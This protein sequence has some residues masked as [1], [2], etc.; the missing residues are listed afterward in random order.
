MALSAGAR[1]GPYEILSPLGAGGMG[2]VYRARDSRLGREVA[3]KVLPERFADDPE[4]M[5]RFEREARAVA[6]L[7]HPNIL[8]LHDAGQEAGVSYAVMELLEGQTLREEINEGRIPARKAADY[9]RQTADGL[10]AA[11]EKGV[12]HRDLKPENLFLTRDGRVKILDFGLARLTPFAQASDSLSPTAAVA[13]EPGAILGTVGYMSPEQVRGKPADARSDIFSL[14]AVLYEM[15]TGRRAFGRETAAESMT[16]ILREEPEEIS[17]SGGRISTS[18]DHIVRRCLE[19][20][21]EQRF[22]SARDLSFAIAEAGGASSASGT[23]VPRTPAPRVRWRALLWPAAALVFA[24]AA[25]FAG[26]RQAPGAGGEEGWRFQQLTFGRSAGL[27]SL[28]PDGAQFL[29]VRREGKEQD[30]FLQRVGGQNAVDLTAGS[31]FDNTEPAFSPDGAHVAFRSDRDGGGIY[32]MGAT[33]ESVHRVVD[34]GYA[35]SWSPDGSLLVYTT[36]DQLDPYHLGTPGDVLTVE[37]QTGKKRKVFDGRATEDANVFKNAVAPTWSPH[38]RRIAFFG[39]MGTGSQRDLFT[40]DMTAENPKPVRLT[41]DKPLDWAPVWAPDGRSIYFGSDRAGTLDLYRIGVDEVTGKA[42][43]DPRRVSVPA[44]SA[45]PFTLSRDGSRI[46]FEVDSTNY[47]IQRFAFDRARR[48]LT[49][50]PSMILSG[51]PVTSY[52]A[53]SPDGRRLLVESGVTHEVLYTCDTG[54]GGL[55]QLTDDEFKNRQPRW[56]DGGKRIL[57]YS[58]RGGPYQLWEIGADGGEAKVLTPP[59]MGEIVAAIPTPG[60]ERVATLIEKGMTS[61]IAVLRRQPDGQYVPETLKG[62]LPPEGAFD[63]PLGWSPDGRLLLLEGVQGTAIYS[64]ETGSLETIAGPGGIDG[65]WV[66]DDLLIY[67]VS[68]LSEPSGGA[69]GSGSAILLYDR[70][71]KARKVLHRFPS[72]VSLAGEFDLSPDGR[73]LYVITNF[74]RSEIWMMERNAGK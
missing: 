42:T 2:E 63:F 60:G 38:G 24:A 10:A 66:S 18:L 1:L 49:E 59:S 35:P 74:S 57:F 64:P 62:P 50:T 32:V 56:I 39:L 3:I 44:G 48:E 40:L 55:A 51:L 9:A 54:G 17:E 33:G 68:N 71:T 12:V 46:A 14:G 21:P 47:G 22:Q 8:A 28:S 25:Y 29:S 36:V 70:K 16:A 11:H 6:G 31:G 15:L 67:G 69:S 34:E 4:A 73:S 7:S 45:G 20:K 37:V 30:I 27:P 41:N 65:V 26:R 19:K 13:T 61:R 23:A 72:E 58:T 52:V 5:A 43:S 53:V